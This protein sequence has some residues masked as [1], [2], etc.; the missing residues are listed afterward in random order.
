M[1]ADIINN[2]VQIANVSKNKYIDSQF[3]T[4]CM[5]N[6]TL[7]HFLTLKTSSLKDKCL[8]IKQNK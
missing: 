4:I 5:E 2:S 6:L 1:I 3:D 8:S 7:Q